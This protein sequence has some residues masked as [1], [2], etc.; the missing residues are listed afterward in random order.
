MIITW[1]TTLRNFDVCILWLDCKQLTLKRRFLAWFTIFGLFLTT[2]K[3][4]F[5]N[6]LIAL[7][8]RVDELKITDIFTNLVSDTCKYLPQT[9][10][11]LFSG[12]L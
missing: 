9:G 6:I 11:I 2:C 3:D 4:S 1:T 5:L 12:C 7:A 10:G 8:F